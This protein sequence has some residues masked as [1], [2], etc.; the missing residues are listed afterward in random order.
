MRIHV[1]FNGMPILYKTLGRKKEL[2]FEFPGKTLRDLVQSLVRKYGMAMK[3][4]LLDSRGDV[5]MEI[6]VVLNDR[7]YL[8]E[9]RMN[10]ELK[11]GDTLVFMGA[12]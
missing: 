6:R 8:V 5:D 2:L 10:A 4:A 3:K 9:D 11:E 7:N 1:K 12:S